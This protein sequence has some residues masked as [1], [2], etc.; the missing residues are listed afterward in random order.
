[1]PQ[2]QHD[3]VNTAPKCS[4][5]QQRCIFISYED[6]G[7]RGQTGCPQTERLNLNTRSSR[8]NMPAIIKSFSQTWEH[9]PW[10]TE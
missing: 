8:N 2:S 6:F 3:H 4:C 9:V 7:C 1:M 5:P 10:R